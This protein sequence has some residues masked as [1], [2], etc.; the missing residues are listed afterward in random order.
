[1]KKS[2]KDIRGKSKKSKEQYEYLLSFIFVYFLIF[3]SRRC[4]RIILISAIIKVVKATMTP[5]LL[6]LYK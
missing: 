3:F 5:V 2:L 6:N 4:D 1:M